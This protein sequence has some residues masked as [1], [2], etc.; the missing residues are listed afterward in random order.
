MEEELAELVVE[1]FDFVNFVL[2]ELE[3]MLGY[4]DLTWS[5]LR[6]RIHSRIILEAVA[7]YDLWI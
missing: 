1:D 7:D 4:L 5:C 3:Y 6:R 2:V